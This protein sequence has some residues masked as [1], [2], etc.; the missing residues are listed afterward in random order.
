MTL[1]IFDLDKTLLCGDSDYLWGEFMVKNRIVDEQQYRARNLKFY[2]DYEHG[3]L[4]NDAYLEFSLEPLT[5]YSIEELHAWRHEFVENWIRPILAPGTA[6][7]LQQHRMQQHHLMMISATNLF[8]T[9]PIAKM[10]DLP[11]VLSTEPEIINNRY[12][13]R[14]LGTATY[15]QG[16][17]MALKK[18]LQGSEHT[19]DG[20]FFYSDSMNDLPL[21]ELVDNPVAVNP[22]PELKDIAEKRGWDIIDLH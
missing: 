2:G 4:D 12:T 10:L 7:L 14:Y 3:T 1:A 19:L 15:Q 22:E 6:A 13:G 8:L 17:V 9:D 5:H 16:K 11:T 18:W 20:A 21:L